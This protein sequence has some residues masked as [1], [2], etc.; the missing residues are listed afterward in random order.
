M[1]AAGLERA[2]EV[3]DAQPAVP[4]CRMVSKLECQQAG[5]GGVGFLL[6]AESAA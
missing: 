6:D 3:I 4:S 1:G 2:T 5:A